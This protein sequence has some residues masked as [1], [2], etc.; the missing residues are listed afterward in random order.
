MRVL[1]DSRPVLDSKE[2]CLPPGNYL[3]LSRSMNPCVEAVCSETQHSFL[4]MMKRFLK[5]LFLS[6]FENPFFDS[7]PNRQRDEEHNQSKNKQV[8]SHQQSGV[9]WEGRSMEDPSDRC[10]GRNL[11]SPKVEAFQPKVFE[12]MSPPMAPL[13]VSVCAGDL[14][15]RNLHLRPR[16]YCIM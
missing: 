10:G 5:T 11:K 16:W 6:V 2:N 8:H 7:L 14:F 15:P 4:R 12:T 3:F 1:R 13:G 9:P